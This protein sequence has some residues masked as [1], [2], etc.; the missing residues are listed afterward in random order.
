MAQILILNQGDRAR[1][2]CL[3]Y[4][5]LGRV[6]IRPTFTL[7]PRAIGMM[8]TKEKS[9]DVVQFLHA[10]FDYPCKLIHDHAIIIILE[11]S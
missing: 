6:V 3:R 1:S 2:L 5:L 4:R 7:E 9:V 10:C 11:R 8:E